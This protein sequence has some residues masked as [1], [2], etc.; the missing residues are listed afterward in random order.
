MSLSKQEVALKYRKQLPIANLKDRQWPSQR[1][2]KAPTWLSTDLR[3]GNQALVNPMVSISGL[4]GVFLLA[5]LAS[6]N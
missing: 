3:D 5:H 4:E 6:D 2:K 1:L